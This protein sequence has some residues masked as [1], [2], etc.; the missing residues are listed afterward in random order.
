MNI[1]ELMHL[2]DDLPDDL[3]VVL[4]CIDGD[5]ELVDV[6][7]SQDEE[8]PFVVLTNDKDYVKNLVPMRDLPWWECSRSAGS[9]GPAPASL[10]QS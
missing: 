5:D 7:Y 8:G 3:P 6:V 10:N 2:I 4:D 9:C 1:S